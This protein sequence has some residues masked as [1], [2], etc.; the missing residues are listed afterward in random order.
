MAFFPLILTFL[1]GLSPK[2]Y[3]TL[4]ILGSIAVGALY[5]RHIGVKDCET[6]QI[7]TSVKIKEKQDEVATHRPDTDALIGS[8]RHGRF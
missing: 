7:I 8:L 1:R 6:K 4:A 3:L 2:A 5:M